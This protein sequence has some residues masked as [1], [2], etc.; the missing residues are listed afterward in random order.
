M[1]DEVLEGQIGSGKEPAPQTSEATE[2]KV[3]ASPQSDEGQVDEQGSPQSG[4]E[5]AVA[6]LPDGMT[7][8]ALAKA[9]KS[10]QGEYTKGQ[11]S[12]KALSDSLAPYGGPEKMA[13]WAQ[14]LSKNQSFANWVKS[15]QQKQSLG[16][17]GDPNSEVDEDTQKA[18]GI[19]NRVATQTVDRLY[20]DKVAPIENALK[21]ERL[22]DNMSKM[23]EDPVYSNW[24]DYQDQMADI[25]ETLPASMQDNPSQKDLQNIYWMAVR[26]SGNFEAVMQKS[27]EKML[28]SKQSKSSEVPGTNSA[29]GAHKKALTVTEAFEQ[30]KRDSG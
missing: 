25:A 26:D 19:V 6:G 18:L 21:Q 28:K 7:P 23:D 17:Q 12:S 27:Y 2:D 10:L 24:R 9:Y 13:Q 20:Q 5:Q 22:E 14:Y 8:E 30:A 11:Q 1:A 15:E 16:T 3:E 4:E 29:R